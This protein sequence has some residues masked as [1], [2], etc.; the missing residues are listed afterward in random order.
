MWSVATPMWVAPSSSMVRTVP[1][2]PRVAATSRS[3]FDVRCDG[4]AKWY[5]NSS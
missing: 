2:T 4:N 5:R 3:P 1:N